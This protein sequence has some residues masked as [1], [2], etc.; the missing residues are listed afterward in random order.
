MENKCDV[1]GTEIDDHSKRI[2][3]FALLCISELFNEN[4]PINVSIALVSNNEIRTLNREYRGVDV[5]TDVLS[6][7]DNFIT[8]DGYLF[9]GDI[10]ISVTCAQQDKGEKPLD[11]YLLSLVAHGLLHLSGHDHHTNKERQEIIKQGERLVEKY[12]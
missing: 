9:I 6:F 2:Q 11:E 4:Y 7:E 8:P 12:G 5:P 1:G 3:K 10:I